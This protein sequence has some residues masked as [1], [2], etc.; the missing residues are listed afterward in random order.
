MI[1]FLQ[2][3][4]NN[5]SKRLLKTPKMYFLDTGLCRYL[6]QWSTPETLEAGALSGAIL[7]TYVISELLK[8]YWYNGLTPFFYYY[9]DR[10]QKEVDLLIEQNNQL[11]PIEI[12]K[13][14]TPGL[15]AIKNFSV[16]KKLDKTIGSGAVLCLKET[17]IPIASDVYA[18]PVAYL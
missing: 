15:S 6:T 9:R 2:P 17:D 14:A 11:Y 1:Y 13:T 10:D 16:L 3:Y 18:I 7:E 4:H 8:S 12:K 5:L